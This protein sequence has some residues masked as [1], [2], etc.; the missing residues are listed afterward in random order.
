MTKTC[1]KCRVLRSVDR[2]EVY[3]NGYGPRQRNT[4]KDCRNERLKGTRKE[5]SRKHYTENREKL[6]EKCKKYYSENRDDRREYA[7]KYYKD[8]RDLIQAKTVAKLYG[9]SVEEALTLRERCCEICGTDGEEYKKS[10]HIDHCHITGK[11][12]GTL[13]HS[14]NTALGLM[15]EDV[16][17]LDKMKEYI[18]E[19]K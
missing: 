1:K 10:N 8:N 15:K 18:N 7:R 16:N 3:D 13:C 2:F 6:L 9:I 4:C 5:S 17:L 14:C 12:R 19:H 11:V